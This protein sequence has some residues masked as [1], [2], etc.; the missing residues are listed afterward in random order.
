MRGPGTCQARFCSFSQGSSVHLLAVVLSLLDSCDFSG[1]DAAS[2]TVEGPP[3]SERNWACKHLTALTRTFSSYRT[4][5]K[6]PSPPADK[7]GHLNLGGRLQE[8][9]VGAVCRGTVIDDCWSEGDCS[10]GE[11]ENPDGGDGD[12][13]K[14]HFDRP[15]K[16]PCDNH[17]LSHLLKRQKEGSLPAG[18]SPGPTSAAPE[19]LTLQQELDRDPEAQMLA[20]STLGCVARR[21][22]FRDGKGGVHLSN[23]GQARL[24]GNVFRDLNYAVRCIQNS[25]VNPIRLYVF[26]Y[27]FIYLNSLSPPPPLQIVMLRNEVRECRASGVFLRLSAHGLIAEN[28]IRA[29]G[30]AGLD[31][32]KGANPIIVVIAAGAF[33]TIFAA[34]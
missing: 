18:S 9:G 14:K 5:G 22:L 23:Y 33:D 15:Y 10:D 30:E 2:V 19:L 21:C 27:L 32:R 24:E 13:A 8:T 31:I 7:N 4:S 3:V 20:A 25:T 6:N 29:N 34:S 17:G 11:E 1:S 16:I 26:V 28:D 12:K